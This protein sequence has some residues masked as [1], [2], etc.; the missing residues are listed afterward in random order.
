MIG[1]GGERVT[2]RLVARHADMWNFFQPA[3]LWAQRNA[4]LDEWCVKEGRDP[5]EIERTMSLGGDQLDAVD[6]AVEA[7]AQM[8]II[9]G[10]QPFD[11]GPLEQLIALAENGG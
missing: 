9:R 8:L 4:I 1:G 7:G 6:D 5:S 11:M 2:L 3:D 10:V